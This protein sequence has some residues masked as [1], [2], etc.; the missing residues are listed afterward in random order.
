MTCYTCNQ[1]I[2]AGEE[3]F[4]G[5][6]GKPAHW[7][8]QPEFSVEW[9][10]RPEYRAAWLAGWTLARATFG[11]RKLTRKPAEQTRLPLDRTDVLWPHIGPMDVIGL[12][13]YH[14]V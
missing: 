8:C 13:D 5:V 9:S 14:A 7:H 12:E 3:Y 11:P 6:N 4:I 1:P 10:A 2:L